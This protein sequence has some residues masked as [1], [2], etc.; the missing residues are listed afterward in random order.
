MATYSRTQT[1]TRTS[2]PILPSVD[3]GSIIVRSLE[4]SL[5]D[6]DT[7]DSKD[8][9]EAITDGINKSVI[10]KPSD[11]LSNKNRKNSAGNNINAL[12]KEEKDFQ[13][14]KK[15][16]LQDEEKQR[17]N[18]LKDMAKGYVDLFKNLESN[19]KGTFEKT[20][21]AVATFTNNPLEGFDKG[22]QAVIKGSLGAVDKL[23]NTQIKLPGAKND[24]SKEDKERLAPVTTLIN[25]KSSKFEEQMKALIDDNK[26]GNEKIS[27][28]LVQ[29]SNQIKTNERKGDGRHSQNVKEGAVKEKKRSADAE[30]ISGGIAQTNLVLG[31]IGQTITMVALG[32]I[33]ALI[34]APIVLGRISEGI[35]RLKE[36]FSHFMDVVIPDIVTKA[37]AWLGMMI[38][39]FIDGLTVKFKPVLNQIIKALMTVAHPLDKEKRNAA[40][41]EAMGI[42]QQTYAEYAKNKDVVEDY[43]ACKRSRKEQA[44]REEQLGELQKKKSLFLEKKGVSDENEL[45]EKGLS[46]DD[47]WLSIQQEMQQQKTMIDDLKNR[48]KKYLFKEYK[49]NGK[50]ITGMDFENADYTDKLD[51]LRSVKQT[52][53][54]NLES[55]TKKYQERVTQRESD[56]QE[57]IAKG[58][59]DNE[60]THFLNRAYETDLI[61]ALKSGTWSRHFDDKEKFVLTDEQ[62]AEVQRRLDNKEYVPIGNFEQ[63]AVKGRAV[64][65]SLTNLGGQLVH[66]VT[67][68]TKEDPYKIKNESYQ[69]IGG[70]KFNV[71][72]KVDNTWV[73]YGNRNLAGK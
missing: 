2:S 38:E 54:G 44:L 7:G 45:A 24:G 1:Q 28:N 35:L 34:A 73:N 55:E 20:F 17:K 13:K 8:M 69:D 67:V 68:S 59:G 48:R 25:E 36:G 12:T 72:Q 21:S 47:E 53:D 16:N 30:K 31:T 49:I 15:K 37:K 14:L 60:F 22:L 40:I 19:L 46:L 3:L 6:L 64:E 57:T 18:T 26:I 61:G 65:T 23:M 43:D 9:S 66:D 10:G 70:S 71:Q 56:Y 33:A 32:I 62:R 41:V 42:E 50:T 39:N 52:V 4:T 63:L 11:P 29:L 5:K 51:E 27:S 58:H